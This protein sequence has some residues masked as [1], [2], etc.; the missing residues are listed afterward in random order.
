MHTKIR[1]CTHE[2]NTFTLK[3]QMSC[4]N[5]SWLSKNLI[6]HNYIYIPKTSKLRVYSTFKA[7]EKIQKTADHIDPQTVYWHLYTLE[8]SCQNPAQ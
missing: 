7:S 8:N 5:F 1:K 2:I 3:F 4:H 6:M